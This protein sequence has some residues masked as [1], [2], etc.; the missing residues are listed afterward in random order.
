MKIGIDLGT[1]FSC[2]GY[3]NNQEKLKIV[4]DSVTKAQ[5]TPSVI[6]IDNNTC[7]VGQLALNKLN[8]DSKVQLCWFF[9]RE[10]GDSKVLLYGSDN[11]EWTA[12]ALSAILLKKLVYDVEFEA[13][14]RVTSATITVPVHFDSRQRKGVINSAQL[15]GIPEVI[16]LDEPVAAA[17]H[18]GVLADNSEQVVLVYDLGGGTFDVT[19]L[20]VEKN[21]F[22]TLGS[23]GDNEIGGKELDDIVMDQIIRALSNL[24]VSVNWNNYNIQLLRRYAEKVKIHFCTE[25]TNHTIS[26]LFSDWNGSI[27]IGFSEFLQSA[28]LFFKKTFSLTKYCVDQANI[29]LDKIDKILFVGGSTQAFFLKRLFAD[30]FDIDPQNIVSHF[31][32]IA[33]AYGATIHANFENAT[34]LF[35]QNLPELQGMTG[36]NIASVVQDQENGSILDTLIAKN[37]PLPCSAKRTYFKANADQKYLI[38]NL[39]SYLDDRTHIRILDSITIGPVETVASNYAIELELSIDICGNLK[40]FVID[41]QTGSEIVKELKYLSEQDGLMLKQ[42]MR[43]EEM[44]INQISS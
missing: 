42:K 44:Y 28:G 13:N 26:V 35:G 24:K 11:F 39:V 20:H 23:V 18:Y 33:V 29:S 6:Y 30:Y 40:V 27:Q 25:G 9:K 41:L 5:T 21:K 43:L 15:A 10:L 8:V 37:N 1:T 2:V 17:L 16:I 12:E 32:N 31:P 14:K 22:Q 19:I 7:L 36:F 38:I 3:V 4:T 34:T